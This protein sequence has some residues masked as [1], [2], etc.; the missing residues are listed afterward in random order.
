MGAARARSVRARM[1]VG[2]IGIVSEGFR[3]YVQTSPAACC[4]GGVEQ[5]QSV[6]E[7]SG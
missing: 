6:V 5:R 3:Q 7:P 1:V 2:P 4:P